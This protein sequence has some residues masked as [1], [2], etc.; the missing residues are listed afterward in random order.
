MNI[1]YDQIKRIHGLMPKEIKADKTAKA[2]L[3]QQFTND[4]NRKSTAQLTF[5]E[6]NQLIDSLGGV[7]IPK[8]NA[9][10]LKFDFNNGQHRKVLSLCRQNNW[11]T[12][13]KGKL[14]ADLSAL[15]TWLQSEKSP[16]K[17]PIN[18]MTPTE[19]SKII[20]ALDNMAQYKWQKKAT[21]KARV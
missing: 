13:Y 17:K 16:V 4:A 5:I 12:K 18:K 8:E 11:E 6:A 7:F 15:A 19:L 1:T 21:N 14:V 3:V 10:W 20:V 9:E 2:Y